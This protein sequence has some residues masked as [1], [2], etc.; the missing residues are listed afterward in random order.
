MAAL[1][2]LVDGLGDAFGGVGPGG[3]T[4]A[5]LGPQGLVDGPDQ[6]VDGCVATG[7]REG[8]HGRQYRST[9][10]YVFPMRVGLVCKGGGRPLDLPAFS[11][12]T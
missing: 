9:F 3:L 7:G 2:R 12:R 10:I 5:E 4:T 8:G 6:A 11:P 1:G